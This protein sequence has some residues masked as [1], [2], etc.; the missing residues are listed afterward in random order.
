M[1]QNLI[2]LQDSTELHAYLTLG[3]NLSHTDSVLFV[4]HH[5][6]GQSAATWALLTHLL[7]ASDPELVSVLS[8]DA[9]AHGSSP[10]SDAS[11]LSLQQMTDDMRDVLKSIY[12]VHTELSKQD[13]VLVGHSLGAP[14]VVQ[15]ALTREIKHLLGLIMIDIVEGSAVDAL[16]TLKQYLNMRPRSF[17]TEQAAIDWSL[18]SGTLRNLESAKISIP[19]LI[20]QHGGEF[21]WRTDLLATEKHWLDW[22]QGLS[23][24]FLACK[25]AKLL[26]LAHTDRL[27]KTLT[28]AQIQGKFQMEVM[29]QCGHMMQEDAPDQVSQVLLQFWKRNS[30][31]NLPPAL[32]AK[33]ANKR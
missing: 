4:L 7:H 28:I 10:S 20:E 9:R 24:N 18:R 30:R 17:P 27:D 1:P 12:E 14:V 11:L 23:D 29:T 13:T 22:F 15:V 5:G 32:R 31:Q 21:L 3:K 16:K 8:F 19:T 25:C 26:L 33:L 6:A 2:K